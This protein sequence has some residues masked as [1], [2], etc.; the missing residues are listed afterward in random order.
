MEEEI[1]PKHF[2]YSEDPLGMS[3]VL[4]KLILEVAGKGGG[5][6]GIT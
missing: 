3:D 4:E 5:P 6:F 2:G 1:E